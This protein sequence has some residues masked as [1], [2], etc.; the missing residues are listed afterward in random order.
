MEPKAF[1]TLLQRAHADFPGAF[2]G[3]G[4]PALPLAFGVDKTL[5]TAWPDMTRSS[6]RRFLGC[7]CGSPTYLKALAAGGPRYHLDGSTE[8]EVSAVEQADAVR[9]LAALK[10]R[11]E[12]SRRELAQ[13]A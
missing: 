12:A 3:K 1:H 13:A 2:P 6:T 7:Y 5:R 8:G 11:K 4:E 9:R 10:K